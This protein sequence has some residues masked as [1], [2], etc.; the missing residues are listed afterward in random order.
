MFLLRLSTAWIQGIGASEARNKTGGKVVS[1][2]F[3]EIGRGMH[4]T[5]P[6]GIITI[7]IALFGMEIASKQHFSDLVYRAYFHAVGF[8]TKSLAL[9][10]DAVSSLI[11]PCHSHAHTILIFLVL[12]PECMPF[13]FPPF[14][15]NHVYHLQDIIA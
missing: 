4:Q 9:V 7:N 1:V 11:N 14:L 15:I 13:Q 12:L 5:R 6:N 2:L 10:A 8:R 3:H